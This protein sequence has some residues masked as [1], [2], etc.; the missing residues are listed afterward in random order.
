MTK[1]SQVSLE[2][3][4]D[5]RAEYNLPEKVVYCTK[6]V[7][8]NQR[9][10]IVFDED[11]I[12]NA[13]RFWERKDKTIDW[14]E[15]EKELRD[16]CDRFRRND[17]RH[18]V[19]VPSSGGKDSAYVAH[20]LKYEYNMNPLTATWAPH[21]YTKIGWQNFQGL[22]HAGLDNILGTPNGLAHRKMTRICT[23]EMGEPFQ[24]F[25]YGQIWFPVQIAVGYDIPFIMDGENGETE[26]GGDPSSDKPGYSIE[27]I[28]KYAFSGKPVEYWLDYGFSK[29][30]LHI[31]MPPSMESI[32]EKKIQRH[33]FSYYKD[34][35]PQKHYY[36]CAK[37][38]GFKANP[39]G[40]SEATYS[41]YASLDDQ[42]DPFHFYF[43]LLKFGIARATSDAAHEIREGLITRE[44]GVLLVRRFDAEFPKKKY[45]IFLDYCELTDRQFK[46][47]CE[48]WRNQNLW[49]RKGDEWVLKNQVS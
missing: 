47:I 39:E 23:A 13:C 46:D 30:D 4:I 38:T 31:Y 42:I 9:P 48:R 19:V 16:L 17:G 34:W 28:D 15:R 10:R 43:S 49:E 21:I 1:I 27:D 33:Y 11:G 24:P 5:V 45:Q 6:C 37:N 7:I 12:C 29:Q 22:I 26:Y 35:R 2:Q 32:E 44:E 41:K 14:N 3:L 40:R 18:D 36:Y 8:S 20:Q 25:I